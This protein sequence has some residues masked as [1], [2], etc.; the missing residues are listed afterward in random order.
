MQIICS[1]LAA[2]E[3][4]SRALSDAGFQVPHDLQLSPDCSP[5][6]PITFTPLL[7]LPGELLAQLRAIPDTTFDGADMR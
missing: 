6:L 7:V 1:T 3:Q 2:A 4:V 5:I